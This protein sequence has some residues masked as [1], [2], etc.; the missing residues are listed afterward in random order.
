V[1]LPLHGTCHKL[2]RPRSREPLAESAAAP[3]TAGAY[4]GWMTRRMGVRNAVR[5]D[6]RASVCMVSVRCG[7]HFSGLGCA[8]IVSSFEDSLPELYKEMLGEHG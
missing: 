3:H 6:H 2:P 5:A 7:G 8:V 1:H 4:D